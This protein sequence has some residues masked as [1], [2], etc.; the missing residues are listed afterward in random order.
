MTPGCP[1]TCCARRFLPAKTF[2][3]VFCA[4]LPN[5]SSFHYSVKPYFFFSLRAAQTR[6]W[7]F[8]PRLRI[9]R[10]AE[11]NKISIQ[12]RRTA[13]NIKHRPDKSPEPLGPTGEY[14]LGHAMACSLRDSLQGLQGH[15]PHLTQRTSSI[16]L[17]PTSLIGQACW[18]PGGSIT[19]CCSSATFKE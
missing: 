15:L 2:I 12:G 7:R 19:T 18:P 13:Q 4:N 8:V 14:L 11:M 5:L 6:C 10:P 9:V 16:T 17:L 3:V 1:R